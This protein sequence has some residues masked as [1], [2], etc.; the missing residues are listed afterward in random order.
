MFVNGHSTN[1]HTARGRVLLVRADASTRIGTGHVM[2]CLALAQA[3]Q[4][5]GGTA[6]FALAGLPSPIDARLADENIP[7]LR[8]GARPGSDDDARELADLAGE[9]EAD[10]VVVDGYHFG[11][12]YQLVLKDAGLQLLM[13][14]DFV[15]A[16]HYAADIVLNQNL[17]ADDYRY[18][19]R[20]GY[21]C[22]LL[23]PSYALL[24]REFRPWRQWRRQP[25][26]SVHNVLISLGGADPDNVSGKVVEAVKP[27]TAGGIEAV[28]V[29]GASN[30]HLAALRTAVR[31][32]E[33]VIR[34][35]SSVGNMPA[36]MA[37]AD[38]AVGAGGSSCLERAFLGLPSL[39]VILADNQVGAAAACAKAG[40]A[41]NL[42]WHDRL[43]APEIRDAL[44][45]LIRRRDLRAVM[46]GRGPDLVDGRGAE[47]VIACLAAPAECADRCHALPR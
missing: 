40:I 34:V 10:W 33:H 28:V 31:G 17:G 6:L 25:P 20:E 15:H 35:Q 26:R 27:L 23:G 46:A 18:P 8:I 39:L 19:N 30:P 36:L 21:T 45:E 3:W 41:Q 43:S 16:E 38:V 37:W 5:Q 11:A 22:P 24:R 29:A 9:R 4:D 1:G 13:L 44:A 32:F 2:R 12:D 47:R 14:D 7:V 42:G